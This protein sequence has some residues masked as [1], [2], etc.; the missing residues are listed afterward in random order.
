MANYGTLQ[1]LQDC[2][3]D[4]QEYIDTSTILEE[5]FTRYLE[6]ATRYIDAKLAT[7]PGIILPLSPIPGVIDDI[8]VD[9]A[10]CY[11]LKFLSVEKDPN[12]TEY[13]KQFCDDPIAMLE[14]LIEKNPALFVPTG[15][16]ASLMQ[17][18]MVGKKRTF[19]VPIDD[20]DSDETSGTMTDW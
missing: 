7:V 17:S 20:E 8:A 3:Q 9:L 4:Y 19:T 11:T 10:V 12:A 13:M 1:L 5:Q 2:L 18:N 15:E 6:R 14:E 16:A